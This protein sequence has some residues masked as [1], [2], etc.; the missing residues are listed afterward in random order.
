MKLINAI[1][2]N[3]ERKKFQVLVL[4]LLTIAISGCTLKFD[5][6]ANNTSMVDQTPIPTIAPTPTY[7]PEQRTVHVEILGSA[8]NPSEL[9]VVNGT[10]VQWTN[11][12][13]SQHAIFINNI[14]SP[15]LN[16]RETWNYTFDR[17]G[18]FEYNCTIQSWMP[19]GRIIV[20]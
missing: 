19:H 10:I 16:K 13:S 12:D 9:T 6:P 15:K 8:F 7:L 2:M 14:S 20:R 3:G 1:R 18:T 4:I 5:D 11:K 17:S